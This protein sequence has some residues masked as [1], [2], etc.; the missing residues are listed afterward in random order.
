M[1]NRALLVIVIAVV[2]LSL[3]A[4]ASFLSGASVEDVGEGEMEV[5]YPRDLPEGPKRKARRPDNKP[6]DRSDGPEPVAVP[7]NLPKLNTNVG[8]GVQRAVGTPGKGYVVIDL[9]AIGHSDLANKILKCHEARASSRLDKV[10]EATGL[11][12]RE[13]VE[14]VGISDGVIALGGRLGTLKI[15]KELG[16][17]QRYGDGGRIY[18]VARQPRDAKAG[19]PDKNS[20][21]PWFVAR[22]GDGLMLAGD[23][24]QEVMKAID[25][26][27]GR[28]RAEVA[29]GGHADVRGRLTGS[30][31]QELLAGGEND[32]QLAPIAELAKGVALRMNVEDHVALSVDME[33]E[34]KGTATD[35]SAALKSA[36]T[37]A[38][39]L[40]RR[41]GH[42]KTAWLLDQARFHKPGNEGFALDLAVPG[43]FILK[44]LG[45]D[46]DGNRIA[47]PPPSK[48]TPTGNQGVS[49]NRFSGHQQQS[50]ATSSGGL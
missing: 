48:A 17:G 15:P 9:G 39:Q 36:V 11:N 44:G 40:A 30:D 27:E 6:E 20:G 32:A 28:E 3:L 4:M 47:A 23:T 22:V 16:E 12:L 35:L 46:K 34:D 5:V 41:E 18:E 19:K 31:L 25:R 8:T 24:R 21:K 29:T 26:A 45:C 14:Q 13:D 43:D 33:A 10:R 49:L 2:V 1:K 50:A 38:R 7:R 37:M 42:K